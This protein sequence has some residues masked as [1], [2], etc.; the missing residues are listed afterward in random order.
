MINT[1]Q[2]TGFSAVELLITLFVAVAFLVAGYQLYSLI[3]KDSGQTRSEA[4]ASNVAYDYMR[5]L[6]VLPAGNCTAGTA[7]PTTSITV[8]GLSAVTVTVVVTC[9]YAAPSNNV[10]KVDVTVLYNSPQQT[11]KY[12]TY[13]KT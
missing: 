13:V 12:S 7:L 4:R 6:S 1:R 11:M 10:S 2:Q 8:T 9:P 5:R 3:I